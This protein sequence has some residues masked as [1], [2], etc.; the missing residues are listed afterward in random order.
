M[1]NLSRETLIPLTQAAKLI[2][3]CGVHIST[4]H[5]WRLRGI[6]GVRLE[7]I[8]IGGKRFTSVEAIDRFIA[9]TVIDRV[10]TSH[11]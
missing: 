6:R 5:R 9:Q 10:D 7:T 11:A 1:I 2:P 3:G 4:L 8:L